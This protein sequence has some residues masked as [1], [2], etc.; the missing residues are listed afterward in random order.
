MFSDEVQTCVQVK[1]T[2]VRRYRS[3][4][5]TPHGT[6]ALAA[7]MSTRVTLLLRTCVHTL[8]T[9]CYARVHH[10]HSFFVTRVCTPWS[11]FCCAQLGAS[12]VAAA[13]GSSH[14]RQRRS[15][16][17]EEDAV[18]IYNWPARFFGRH[19]HERDNLSFEQVR[20]R[21]WVCECGGGGPAGP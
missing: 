18:L 3:R 4:V 17:V 9:L 20:C 8:A 1:Y 16:V 19:V 2:H 13:R 12:F 6:H 14:N 15:S 5:Q 21:V 10:G 11:L 7:H